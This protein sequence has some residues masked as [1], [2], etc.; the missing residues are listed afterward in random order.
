MHTL[1]KGIGVNI[2]KNIFLIFE[3]KKTKRDS[4]VG[5]ENGEELKEVNLRENIIFLKKYMRKK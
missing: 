3:R 2:F 5:V 1:I 4:E